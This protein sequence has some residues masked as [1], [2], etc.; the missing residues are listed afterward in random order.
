MVV[1]CLSG[2]VGEAF[3]CG[4]PNDDS[5]R[6]DIQ[7]AR[8][9]LARQY[10]V[11]QIGFRLNR[12]RDSARALVT[13]PWARGIIPVIA[14]ALLARGSLDAQEIYELSQQAS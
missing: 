8:E 9:I 5:D 6:T 10:D 12:L 13:T 3:F 1:L 2:P 4:P 7:M 11:L 14:D